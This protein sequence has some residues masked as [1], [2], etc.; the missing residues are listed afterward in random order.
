MFR[1]LT[2]L[3]DR[4]TSAVTGSNN[5]SSNGND[6]KVRHLQAMGFPEQESR[7]AL[8][9]T[10]GN[11]ERAAELLLGSWTP[12][13]AA[14]AARPP[15]ID[16]DIALRNALKESLQTEEQSRLRQAQEASLQQKQQITQPKTSTK[17][18][19]ASKAG[20]AAL[21][22]SSGSKNESVTK[23]TLAKHHPNVKVPEKL[24]NKTKEEQILRCC[25]RLRNHPAAVD[26]L[27]KALTA[28]R[29][30]PDNS[31]FRKIDKTTAGFKRSLANAPG[32]E[33]LLKTMNFAQLGPNNLVLDRSQVDPALLFLGLSALEKTKESLEYKQAKRNLLFSKQVQD[34]Q[35]SANSSETEAIKRADFMSKCPTEPPK[36]RG[37]LVQVV[38]GQETVKR[39]FDGDD[40]L[41]DVL[42]WLGAQGTVIP[43]K[44]VSREWSLVD[45]NRYPIA[46]IDCEVN[47][48]KTLQYIGCWP[49]GKLEVQ[50]STQKWMDRDTD[51]TLQMGSSRGLGSAPSET[52]G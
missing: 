19:A 45:L 21:I 17:S 47:D 14:T 33:Q 27:Y 37:A 8:Q 51:N 43:E 39:R 3:T 22:R 24:Q 11:V 18:A 7:N 1:K 48:Q 50:P 41:S 12:S 26:T 44:L 6:D 20:Q 31:K 42:N 34:I 30:N 2:N 9:S 29:E 40:V 10:N 52:L 36:G 23:N 32:A 4:L 38:I 25:D 15:P 16:D 13:P 35:L 5:S 46:P 49:S 28:L